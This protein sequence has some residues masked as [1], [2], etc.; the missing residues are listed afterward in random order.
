VERIFEIGEYIVF[1][2]DLW[3]VVRYKISTGEFSGSGHPGAG[4]KEGSR[5]TVG[6]M[7]VIDKEHIL[8]WLIDG[9]SYILKVSDFSEIH[10]FKFP[11]NMRGMVKSPKEN[12]YIL[13]TRE[14]FHLITIK[15]YK[16]HLDGTYMKG[17]NI[18]G[19]CSLDNNIFLVSV[20]DDSK[21]YIFDAKKHIV[22]KYFEDL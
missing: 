17:V 3:N 1:A 2:N 5:Y 10:K 7:G 12:E 14:G 19:I 4:S 8:T 9:S 15:G 11:D 16:I 6:G 21:T 13:A 22:T 20:F 18:Y